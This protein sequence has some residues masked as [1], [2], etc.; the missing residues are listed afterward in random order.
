[1][2]ARGQLMAFAGAANKIEIWDTETKQ[3]KYV[4]TANPVGVLA[5]RPD[6]KGVAWTINDGKQVQVHDFARRSTKTLWTFDHSVMGLAYSGDSSLLA[7]ATERQVAVAENE[8]PLGEMPGLEPNQKIQGVVLSANGEHIAVAVDNTMLVWAARK[9]SQL[10]I[11]MRGHGSYIRA[12]AF[13]RQPSIAAGLLMSTGNQRTL[14]W[15]STE[16]LAQ[17][18]CNKTRGRPLSDKEW[19]R[20][21]GAGVNQGGQCEQ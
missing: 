1:M 3:Q 9:P 13:R 11:V 17:Q 14:V 10:P 8:K 12:M 5:M 21:V 7:A 15:S 19:Q 16:A 4:L 18:V 6:G 2:D 20:W